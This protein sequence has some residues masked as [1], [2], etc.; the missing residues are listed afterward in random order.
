MDSSIL[1]IITSDCNTAQKLRFLFET[2]K[3]NVSVYK[4]K[5]TFLARGS[6]EFSECLL[7]DINSPQDN[8][9]EIFH[10]LKK[11]N[12]SL[13]IVIITNNDDIQEAINAMKLGAIDFIL[14]PYNEQVLIETIQKCLSE[15]RVRPAQKIPQLSKREQDIMALV[16]EGKLNKQIADELSISISTVEHHRRNIMTKLEAKNMAQLISIYYQAQL[17]SGS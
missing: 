9:Q 8:F 3:I 6:P 2:V 1:H 7:I 14:K 13:P 16:M 10:E 12:I 17:D 11:L 15:I 5:D 4:N